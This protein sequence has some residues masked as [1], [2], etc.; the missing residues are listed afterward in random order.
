VRILASAA[1]VGETSLML[2][3]MGSSEE[4]SP[5]AIDGDSK[6]Q[7]FLVAYAPSGVSPIL[8]RVTAPGRA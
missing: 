8:P 5:S 3:P 2:C 4:D 7:E 6:E 1:T